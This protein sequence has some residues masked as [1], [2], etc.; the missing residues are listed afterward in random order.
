MSS[1][2][3]NSRRKGSIIE[4][5]I[6]TL[7]LYVFPSWYLPR[8]FVYLDWLLSVILFPSFGRATT[9]QS[10]PLIEGWHSPAG[11]LLPPT[12]WIQLTEPCLMCGTTLLLLGV[13]CSWDEER[14]LLKFSYHNQQGFFGQRFLTWSHFART[15][16]KDMKKWN[17]MNELYLVRGRRLEMDSSRSG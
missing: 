16:I 15:V 6:S 13:C 3:F 2:T 14:T 17:S 12:P 10:L 5:I 4:F 11:K 8:S 9:K 7:W 1:A